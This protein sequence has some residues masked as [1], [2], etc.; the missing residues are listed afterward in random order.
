MINKLWKLL[1]V[2]LTDTLHS[3]LLPGK[4]NT[5]NN[6][7]NSHIVNLYFYTHCTSCF[8]RQIQKLPISDKLEQVNVH[9]FC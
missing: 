8:D 2:L 6:M 9:N 7:Y 5:T 3:S 1:P 4:L